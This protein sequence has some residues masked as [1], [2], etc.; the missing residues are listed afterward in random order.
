[1]ACPLRAALA[2]D[3]R[4]EAFHQLPVGKAVGQLGSCAKS[5]L[6]GLPAC[7]TPTHPPCIVT[8]GHRSLAGPIY[9]DE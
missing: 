5:L 3:R 4:G 6:C 7:L 2:R 9:G 1:M 8:P